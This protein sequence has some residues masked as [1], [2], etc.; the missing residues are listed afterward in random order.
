[1]FLF[2]DGPAE[3]TI[4]GTSSG[5]IPYNSREVEAI[6]GGK[7]L[8]RLDFD[9]YRKWFEDHFKQQCAPY[10]QFPYNDLIS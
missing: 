8:T 9:M 3:T 6:D 10:S 2:K 4:T 1:M 5:S 7:V